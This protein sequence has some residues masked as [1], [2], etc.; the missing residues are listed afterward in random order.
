MLGYQALLSRAVGLQSSHYVHYKC[1]VFV[2]SCIFMFCQEPFKFIS[3]VGLFLVWSAGSLPYF[4]I[5][6]GVTIYI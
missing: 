3:G 4:P 1:Y 6:L 2:I 5:P